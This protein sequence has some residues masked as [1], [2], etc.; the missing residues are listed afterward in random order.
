MLKNITFFA[1]TLVDCR[2]S[3]WTDCN[4]S[5]VQSR[6]I[7]RKM[8][9]GGKNCTNINVTERTCKLGKQMTHEII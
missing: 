7:T 6:K 9:N 1:F 8:E 4:K 5:K 2:W 3:L